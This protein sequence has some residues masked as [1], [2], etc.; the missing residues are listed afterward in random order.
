M[1]NKI[2]LH[3]AKGEDVK[4]IDIQRKELAEEV[5]RLCFSNDTSSDK[6]YLF[7]AHDADYFLF[8][9]K[10]YLEIEELI[11]S[12]KRL[13]VPEKFLI[14]EFDSFE[15]AYKTAIEMNK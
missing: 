14:Q 12:H 9:T 7:I 10:S 1:E 15:A 4:K 11:K 8:V 6:V 3:Y 5:D 13:I 2:L